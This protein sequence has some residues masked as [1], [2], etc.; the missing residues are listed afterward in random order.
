MCTLG[1][2]MFVRISFNSDLIVVGL[3]GLR[4]KNG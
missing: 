4:A 1:G 3:F 2:F